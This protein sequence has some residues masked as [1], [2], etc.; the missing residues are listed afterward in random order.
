MRQL[1]Q[2]QQKINRDI[3]MELLKDYM[4]SSKENNKGS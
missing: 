4:V 3:D 1:E 2:G